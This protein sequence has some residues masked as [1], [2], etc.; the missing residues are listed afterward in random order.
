[1]DWNGHL[2]QMIITST[3]TDKNIFEEMSSHHSQQKNP[4]CIS[5]WMQS[6]EQQNDLCSFPRQITQYHGNP[7]L[8][9]NQYC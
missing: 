6:Q 8:C 4:K 1:M 3:T 5:T 9:P 2:I 7:S